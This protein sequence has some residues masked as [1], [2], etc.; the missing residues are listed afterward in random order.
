MEQAVRL[1]ARTLSAHELVNDQGRAV[2]DMVAHYARS[3][4]LLVQ[5]DENRLP[6]APAHPMRP[7]AGI[8]PEDTHR[9][10][11]ELL[12]EDGGE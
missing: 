8:S 7:V 6:E 12:L 9:A 2:L 10:I 3:W 11:G 4:R 5:Y 1:L